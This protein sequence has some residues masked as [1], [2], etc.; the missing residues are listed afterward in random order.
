[1]AKKIWISTQEAAILILSFWRDII[2]AVFF[3]DQCLSLSEKTQRMKDDS[4]GREFIKFFR[5]LL[6]I[7][8]QI[9]HSKINEQKKVRERC[10]FKDME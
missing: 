8:R 5:I 6:G 1:M 2:W 4:F 7:I 3:F 9:I 10:Y